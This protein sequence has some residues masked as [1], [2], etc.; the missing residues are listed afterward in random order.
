M[1]STT[2]AQACKTMDCAVHATSAVHTKFTAA[3]TAFLTSTVDQATGP[4]CKKGPVAEIVL[5]KHGV[6]R[7]G[8]ISCL[9]GM[10]EDCL[11]IVPFVNSNPVCH[12]WPPFTDIRSC[13]LQQFGA[14]S[15]EQH[16]VPFR[17]CCPALSTC[18][19]VASW[20]GGCRLGPHA[21]PVNTGVLAH[22]CVLHHWLHLQP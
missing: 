22:Q 8:C 9:Q 12:G 5:R 7:Q 13:I 21:L 16:T 19:A 15:R 3:T 18:A 4:D 2:V 14:A 6:S 11:R 20:A 10:F 1:S 17:N